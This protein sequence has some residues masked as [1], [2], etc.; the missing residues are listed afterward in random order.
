MASQTA[1]CRAAVK[2]SYTAIAN[3]SAPKLSP[4]IRMHPLHR[5]A[6]CCAR[7][8]TCMHGP[9]PARDTRPAAA[10]R[11]AGGTEWRT[12]MSTL[13]RKSIVA[14]SLLLSAMQL[15]PSASAAE[16]CRLV[17]FNVSDDGPNL[18]MAGSAEVH[19]D[20]GQTTIGA[21]VVNGTVWRNEELL[22]Q[23]HQIAYSYFPKYNMFSLHAN[24]PGGPLGGLIPPYTP[25]F[26]LWIHGFDKTN[27]NSTLVVGAG[28][29]GDESDA[30]V[31]VSPC[32]PPKIPPADVLAPVFPTICDIGA[33]LLFPI[34]GKR[35]PKPPKVEFTNTA[36]AVFPAGQLVAL[37][38]PGRK[39]SA[40]L[41]I[42]FR[43]EGELAPGASVEIPLRSRPR[44]CTSTERETARAAD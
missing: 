24:V 28:R 44:S 29:D 25:Y 41:T 5:G 8:C 14:G 18:G 23:L 13:N 30:V 1:L 12:D 9:S 11:T 32:T 35:V 21:A 37:N 43:L 22:F 7:R 34:K 31:S 20:L 40:S 33:D 3:E 4:P 27:H 42:V 26:G 38:L 39:G 36:R 2:H 19:I 10:I 16:V 6:S 15:V 17:T